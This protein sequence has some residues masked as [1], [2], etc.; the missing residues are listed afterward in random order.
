MQSTYSVYGTRLHLILEDHIAETYNS[1]IQAFFDAQKNHLERTGSE[2]I[3]TEPLLINWTE[4]EST[5]YDKFAVIM[6]LLV[7]LNGG[8]LDLKEEDCTSDFLVKL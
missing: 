3:F 7:E 6:N 8:S 4:E 2:W 5:V 1:A